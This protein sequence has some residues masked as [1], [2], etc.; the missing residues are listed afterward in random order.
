MAHINDMKPELLERVLLG[1]MKA[2]HEFFSSAGVAMQ[3]M[4]AVRCSPLSL[5][6]PCICGL[7]TRLAEG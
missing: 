7:C 5:P 2:T 6:L 4:D 3:G 1:S